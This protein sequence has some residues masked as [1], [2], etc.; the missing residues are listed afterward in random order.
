MQWND[1]EPIVKVVPR[2]QA[3]V[4]VNKDGKPRLRITLAESF[5]NDIGHAEHC[6]I[7]I[8]ADGDKIKL[9][10]VFAKDGKFG[11]VNLGRGGARIASVPSQPP[12]PD[13]A[14][15]MEPCTVVS[16]SKTE[17][18]VELPIG[19]WEKQLNRPLPPKSAP[20]KDAPKVGGKANGGPARDPLNLIDPVEYLSKKGMRI[21]KV[22][23]TYMVDGSTETP[24]G[25]LTI[26]NRYRR[27][28]GLP[29]VTIDDIR[30]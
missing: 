12:C 30:I 5:L 23:K 14:R 6:N 9:R 29:D 24:F 26:V 11:I 10:M 8:G 15:E 7:Q 21:S 3:S 28:S 13:G 19:A 17:A 4:Y 18:I 2:V 27:A 22:G 20:A 16:S 25:V 1:L